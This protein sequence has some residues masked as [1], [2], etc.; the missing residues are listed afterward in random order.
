MRIG[1]ARHDANLRGVASLLCSGIW[2]SKLVPSSVVKSRLTPYGYP[3][4]EGTS[5]EKDKKKLK[6]SFIPKACILGH[7]R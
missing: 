7:I 4:Q 2:I 6:P 5:T 3:L 1:C